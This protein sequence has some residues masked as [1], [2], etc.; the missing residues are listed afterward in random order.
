MCCVVL[1]WTAEGRTSAKSI[2]GKIVCAS[3]ALIGKAPLL[4]TGTCGNPYPPAIFIYILE[5]EGGHINGFISRMSEVLSE[6]FFV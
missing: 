4:A 5:L 3:I 2:S 6:V 1:L